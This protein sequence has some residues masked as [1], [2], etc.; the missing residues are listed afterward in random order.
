M[1]NT[2]IKCDYCKKRA[3]RN[4]QDSRITWAIDEEGYYSSKPID[5]EEINGVN[6]HLCDDCE[7]EY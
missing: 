5:Y 3:T 2:T 4:I 7:A 6:H 1:K